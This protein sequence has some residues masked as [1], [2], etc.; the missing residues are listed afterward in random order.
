MTEARP[1]RLVEL[2]SPPT[3]VVALAARHVESGRT[4][5]HN[6]HLPLPSASLIKL[7][8][9][10]AFWEGAEAGR[11]DP[12]ERVDVPAGTSVE[13][14]GV[15]KALAPG[16]QPTWADLATLMITVSDNVATN[17]I[18][19]RLGMQTIQTWIDK[20]GL[21]GTRLER[22]M[23]DRAAMEAG[24]SN[25]TSAADMEM[26]L[27]AVAAE[28]C[29]SDEASRRMR[30]ALEAQQIQDRLPRRLG[31]G[32]RVANKTGNFADVIHDAGI[33]TC[34]GGPLVIAVLTQGV[35]PTW[36]AL[37]AIAEAAAILVEVCA[38]SG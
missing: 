4:W 29:V 7:P 16:L 14:T 30:R 28:T 36:Q 32:V 37:D 21:V 10:A 9:L 19:D 31:D 13:G 25:W 27:S 3:G 18:I 33:V 26:L 34:P 5:R 17:L 35:R 6:E 8:I 23:T 20:S 38:G 2:L 15:L 24:R 1:P 22:R 12:N 11:L